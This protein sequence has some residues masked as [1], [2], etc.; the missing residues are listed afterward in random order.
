M[1][2]F[3]APWKGLNEIQNPSLYLLATFTVHFPLPTTCILTSLLALF[4]SELFPLLHILA[5]R[6]CFSNMQLPLRPIYR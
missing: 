1:S 2:H 5:L 6:M 4:C 3:L